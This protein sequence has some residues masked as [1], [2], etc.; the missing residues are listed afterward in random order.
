MPF[1][2]LNAF[3][4]L[5]DLSGVA[6][7]GD[8]GRVALRRVLPIKKKISYGYILY[9]FSSSGGVNLAQDLAVAIQ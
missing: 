5:G 9:S 3:L 4:K 2:R 8:L 6:A 1:R 7:T